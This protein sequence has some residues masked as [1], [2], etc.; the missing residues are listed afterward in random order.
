MPFRV[1][2]ARL[3]I[4]VNKQCPGLCVVSVPG[5]VSPYSN[6]PLECLVDVGFVGESAGKV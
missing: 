4:W 3:R 1:E 2:G 5:L 6:S